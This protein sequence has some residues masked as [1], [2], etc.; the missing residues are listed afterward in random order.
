MPDLACYHPPAF[1]GLD[2][3]YEDA[4]FI[5]LNKP[6]GLLSVPGRGEH[7]SDCML[8]RLQ[9]SHPEALVIHRLDMPTS[10]IILFALSKQAQSEMSKLFAERKVE[11]EYTASVDGRLQNPSGVIDEPLITDW[12]NRP[13]QKIDYTHGKPAVTRYSLIKSGNDSSLVKLQPV[14]GRSHQLRVHMASIDH[15]ILGDEFYGTEKSRGA[16][17]RLLLH[18]SRLCFIHPF[19]QQKIEI[20]CPAEF[21]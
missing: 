12:P 18:A 4:Q 5:A 19:S 6:S 2:I 17:P 15:P 8:S 3:L 20:T 13:R 10:G 7:K 16:S 1:D 14:T 11:K 21:S 9:A